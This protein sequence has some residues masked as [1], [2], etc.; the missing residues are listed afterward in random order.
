MEQRYFSREIET[1]A[2]TG[3]TGNV[4]DTSDKKTFRLTMKN[5][6]AAPRLT[7]VEYEVTDIYGSVAEK[8]KTDGVVIEGKETVIKE[9]TLKDLKNGVYVIAMKVITTGPNEL[10]VTYKIEYDF[11]V[12]KKFRPGEKLN[13]RIG[14]SGHTS[15]GYDVNGSMELLTAAGMGVWRDEYSWETVERE[16]GIYSVYNM[17]DNNVNAMYRAG[18]YPLFI[19]C[20]GNTQYD[21]YKSVP[22]TDEGIEAYAKYAGF[23][24][25]K[26]RDKIKAIEIWNEYNIKAFNPDLLS[27][28]HYVKMLKACYREIKRVNPEMKVVGIVASGF[29]KEFL[30][31]VF[32]AGGYDYMDVVS[33]HL[34]WVWTQHFD[35]RLWA[36]KVREMKELM[37][38]Y[39]EEKELWI[40]EIGW[41]THKQKER[42]KFQYTEEEQGKYIPRMYITYCANNF[43]QKVF[44][45]DFQDD[46]VQPENMEHH[47]GIVHPEHNV[48]TPFAAKPA[49]IT[50]CA[51]NH[52][53]GN[54][55][56]TDSVYFGEFTAAH[57]FVDRN[58][59]EQT[60]T[61]W[62]TFT[63]SVAL[64][65]GTDTVTVFDHYGNVVYEYKSKDGIYQ[66]DLNNGQYYIKGEFTAFSAAE[67]CK[68]CA[69]KLS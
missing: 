46:G 5:T 69:E 23:L 56:Y 57:R 24:A 35:A 14:A 25:E 38:E 61:V 65:L 17:S 36:S 49:L 50:L 39:G 51:M 67:A 29:D 55:E 7:A 58:S 63:D 10:P 8:G 13:D 33:A 40:T 15:W 12:M 54:S 28:E 4:F 43:G 6:T 41:P 21:E 9:I 44:V 2:E 18:V 37:N 19:A 11:S 66:F 42:I 30:K 1:A 48:R 34:Y 20:Y 52:M 59:G 53:I 16:K 47:F 62:S 27:A 68:K 26:Y 3:H 31:S 22:H 32:D 64:N 45:Y 60:V